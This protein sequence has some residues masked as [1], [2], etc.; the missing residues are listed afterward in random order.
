MQCSSLRA[1]GI[2]RRKLAL[3]VRSSSSLR[4]SPMRMP[5]IWIDPVGYEESTCSSPV[6]AWNI[7][8]IHNQLTD[9]G[10]GENLIKIK[11]FYVVA[12]SEN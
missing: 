7:K 11:Y 5:G 4:S 3:R 2:K 12:V 8:N 6:E 10:K 9:E 1:L